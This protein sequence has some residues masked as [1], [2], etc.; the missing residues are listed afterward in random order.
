MQRAILYIVTFAIG[1]LL[2]SLWSFYLVIRPPKIIL[3]RTPAD[4]GLPAEDIILTTQDGLK[5]S[6]WF[7]QGLALKNS[8]LSIGKPAIVLIHGYPAEKSDMLSI[9][10]NLW[11]DFSLLIYDQRYFGKSEGRYTTLGVK[12]RLD[13]KSALDF[14]E[15]R[16]FSAKDEPASGGKKIGVFGFSLGGAVGIITAAED[17]R[18]SAIASYA[19]FSNLKI[20]GE[21]TYSHLWPLNKPLVQLMLF[22]SRLLFGESIADISPENA[23]TK[24]TIPVFIVHSRED[25]QISFGHAEKLKE[26]LKENPQAEFYFIESGLHGELPIDFD[27]RLKDFFQ[28]A[29]KK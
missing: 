23:A 21:E 15:S 26:K 9:A 29:L 4:Y 10:K 16:G 22:W 12:E 24:L 3:Q 11:P 28:R 19:A 2:V 7:I 14:L 25:E 18:I 20:L 5:L 8:M 1:F 27:S 6:G 13:L 17:Q